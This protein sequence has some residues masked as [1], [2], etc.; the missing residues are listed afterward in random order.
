MRGNPLTSPEAGYT[1]GDSGQPSV[2]ATRLG[3]RRTRL[4]WLL[5]RSARWSTGGKDVEWDSPAALNMAGVATRSLSR[6]VWGIF[7]PLVLPVAG[8]GVYSLLQTTAAVLTQIG[9]LGTPQTL[10]RQPGRKLPIAGLFLH[11]LLIACIVLPLLI[12]RHG[13]EDGWYGVLVA[14]MAVTLIGYG[15]LV[16]RTKAANAFAGVFR[17]EALGALALLLALGGLVLAQQSRGAHEASYVV[18]CALEIGAT[19]VVVL[20]LM[21]STS[22]HVTREE[23]R[24]AGTT[25]VLSSVYS[26]GILVLL[27]LL[28]F[29]RLEMYFLEASPD[30]LRGVAV[31]GLGVQLAS[32][33][34]LFPSAM[35]E[36][37]MPGLATSFASG[38]QEFEERFKTNRQTYRRAFAWVLA[39]SILG[40]AVL[41]RLVFTRYA[42]W[43]WYLVAFATIRVVCSYAGYYSSVLYVARRE[44]WLYLPGLLGV[45]VGIGSNWLLTVRWGVRGAVAAF[46]LTQASVAIATLVAFRAATPWMRRDAG[47]GAPTGA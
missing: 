6:S 21:L 23:F 2:S 43:M 15:I 4:R 46:A 20:T 17:A 22:T 9:I 7:V 14:A 33:P 34:L 25:G 3:R 29:R 10:L 38:W 19:V 26:V 45:L 28:I 18:V 32:L 36:A 47:R 44:R 16:A 31:F 1:V 12:S 39:A 42:P 37:W 5:E 8:Y 27:D 13:A 24:L 35:V 41:V 30:G 11:S 40:P